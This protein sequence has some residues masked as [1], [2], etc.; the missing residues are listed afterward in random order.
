MYCEK[1]RQTAGAY[2][3]KVSGYLQYWKI[4][5]QAYNGSKLLSEH[6]SVVALETVFVD[7]IATENFQFL[8]VAEHDLIP[9]L[10]VLPILALP[11]ENVS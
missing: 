6:I 4:H 5:R 9:R 1:E 2:K 7:S 11:P 3:S 10:D 8:F